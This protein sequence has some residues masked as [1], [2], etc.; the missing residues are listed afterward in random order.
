MEKRT[1]F[2]LCFP[3]QVDHLN[4]L[5]SSVLPT[6]DGTTSSSSQ[7]PPIPDSTIT[8]P[9]EVDTTGTRVPE[10]TA[11]RTEA[12]FLP[13]V[14]DST[15]GGDT[16]TEASASTDD[17]PYDYE[18]ENYDDYVYEY[19]EYEY[20][21]EEDPELEYY[22]YYKDGARYKR[23]SKK[24]NV[25]S[26]SDHSH[27]EEG[28]SGSLPQQ[29]EHDKR[30]K[31][32]KHTHT[33]KGKKKSTTDKKRKHKSGNRKNNQN[34]HTIERPDTS[35]VVNPL[36]NTQPP[37]PPP[38]STTTPSPR[39]IIEDRAARVRALK[40]RAQQ[41][42]ARQVKNSDGNKDIHPLR[43]FS[44]ITQ[45]TK[46]DLGFPFNKLSEEVTWI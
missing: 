36:E 40:L 23:R 19:D 1:C 45:R 37:P 6:L 35:P 15:V 11:S 39:Q 28:R 41:L 5:V 42:R 25:Q 33:K 29:E 18:Y 10:D 2:N 17:V 31:K 8:F 22:D 44:E 16:T 4:G 24:N 30:D 13:G 9:V 38:P 32:Q 26:D 27:H 34:Y 46:R 21:D 43:R 14:E 3:H 20:E 7:V 12:P